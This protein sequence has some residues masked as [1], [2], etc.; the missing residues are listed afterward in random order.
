MKLSA[1]AMAVIAISFTAC[2][3]NDSISLIAEPHQQSLTRDG[4][5]SLASKK[6]HFVMLRPG[7]KVVDS[8]A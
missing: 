5:Q 8:S 7:S 3:I 1:F 6:K 4:I 2:A